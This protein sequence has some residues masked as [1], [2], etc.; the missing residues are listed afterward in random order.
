MLTCGFLVSLLF[1]AG[2]GKSKT[3]VA[4][5]NALHLGA[6]QRHYDS[7]LTSVTHNQT[8]MSK[9]RILVC[10]PSNTAVDELIM[11]VLESGLQ[12]KP[13]PGMDSGKP[14]LSGKGG[15][16][17]G[18]RV[19]YVPSIVRVGQSDSIRPELRN[20]ISLDALVDTYQRLPEESL[21]SR[22]NQAKE[23]TRKQEVLLG[24]YRTV[25]IKSQRVTNEMKATLDQLAALGHD[26]S[27]Q[28]QHAQYKQLISEQLGHTKN[29]MH[30]H[31]KV[32]AGR[33]D[34]ARCEW[35]LLTKQAGR[36]ASAGGGGAGNLRKDRDAALDALRISFLNQ[37]HIVFCTLSGSGVELLSKLDHPFQALIVD[38]A[39]Q[40]T[41]IAALIPLTHDVQH[42]VLVGDPRQLPATVFSQDAAAK[43]MWERSLFERL[44]QSGHQMHALTT[45]YRMHSDIRQFPSDYFY[46]GLLTDAD[47][48]RE[49]SLYRKPYHA[50]SNFQ[51][52]LF[53]D[54]QSAAARGS[55][56]SDEG[57]RSLGNVIEAGVVVNLLAALV[58]QY[59]EAINTRQIGVITFYQK[60]KLILQDQ[61]RRR[62]GVEAPHPTHGKHHNQNQNAPTAAAS[63]SSAAAVSSAAASASASSSAPRAAGGIVGLEHVEVSTVDGFQGREKDIILVSCV[64]GGSSGGLGFVDDVRRM[65]VALTRAK[66]ACWVV[67]D[68]RALR[69]SPHWSAF[70][71]SAT[72]RGRYVNVQPG[73][74]FTAPPKQQQLP[75][76][77]QNRPLLQHQPQQQQQQRLSP[78]PLEPQRLPP[79]PRSQPQPQPPSH[80]PPGSAFPPPPPP[81]LH[82]P[83]HPQQLQPIQPAGFA[84]VHLP[85]TQAGMQ[86]QPQHQLNLP[87]P[88]P[89]SMAYPPMPPLPV[90]PRVQTQEINNR[91]DDAVRK[92]RGALLDC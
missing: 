91:Q 37:A 61:L 70:L 52:L 16:V 47:Y 59:G 34:V 41:E 7:V 82:Q 60:Q 11:R 65:N 10:A 77:P 28:A 85:A 12:G 50:N 5:L 40:C 38:E 24:E 73:T 84:V 71:D 1:S 23:F 3:V 21:L 36:A 81:Q 68:S 92:L 33:L 29:M 57:N 67:G 90:D 19:R 43:R 80:Y 74:D 13:L 55:D 9:P 27:K 88:P 35:A 72:K 6:F 22:L 49:G 26:V 30:T 42:C 31:E 66:F 51:P 44:E 64:R 14:A 86:P 8:A 53:F 25:Y 2:T 46:S 4:L 76:Q 18:N 48:I 39:A 78:Q 17:D 32:V 56:P 89:P 79:P 20:V 54:L 45:Q 62:A 83:P 87:P 58:A 69:K 75:A 63:S 15:F